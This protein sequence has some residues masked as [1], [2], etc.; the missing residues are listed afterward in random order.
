MGFLIMNIGGRLGA[1]NQVA[2]DFYNKIIDDLL[3]RGTRLSGDLVIIDCF[4]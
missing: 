2:I 4:D 1:I 3:L